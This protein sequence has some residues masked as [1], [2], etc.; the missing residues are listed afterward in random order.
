MYDQSHQNIPSSTVAA[1]SHI[2]LITTPRIFGYA[3]NPVSFY[4]CYDNANALRVVLLEVNNTFGEK[5]LYALDCDE[6][7]YGE[8]Q[9]GAE[10]DVRIRPGY[11]KPMK[12]CE[13]ELYDCNSRLTKSSP[14][15]S[16]YNT[17]HTLP[18]AFH[19][20]PFNDRT[21][22]YAI[23]TRDLL[24]VPAAPYLDV[25][26]VIHNNPDP[27]LPA[28][29]PATGSPSKKFMA[30]VEGAAVPLTA[31]SVAISLTRYVVDVFAT[32]PRIMFE[33]AVLHYKKGLKVYPRPEPKVEWGTV[34]VKKP[35]AFE[36]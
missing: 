6:M 25:R 3:F 24:A 15:L 33:A 31:R 1:L 2:T 8:G 7:K 17:S 20:S 10:G 9:N 35:E 32:V 12:A 22:A 27:K 26:I 36:R 29:F 4:F 14:F 16:S 13:F 5:H 19:V 28:D 30:K 21:G 11:V 18:R 34:G 23:Y